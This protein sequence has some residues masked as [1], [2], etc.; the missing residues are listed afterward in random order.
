MNITAFTATGD[1]PEAFE[2]CKA[3]MNRQTVKPYQWIIVDDGVSPSVPPLGVD[4]LYREEFRDRRTSLNKKVQ[5]ILEHDLVKGDALAFIEDD[6]WYAPTYLEGVAAK[7]GG[8]DVFGEGRAIYYNVRNRHWFDN[9]NE[10][11]ASLCQT[12]VSRDFLPM[13]RELLG[14]DIVTQLDAQVW[15]KSTHG[16]VTNPLDG[17]HNCIGMKGMPGRIGMVYCFHEDVF[18]APDPDLTKLRELI[19][20]DAELYAQFFKP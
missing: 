18:G 6:D 8:A 16:L 1:R 7:M 19:G 3:W 17:P 9:Q 14:L 2:L 12:A 11:H 4:Y 13:I 15:P 10:A 5:F 20:D